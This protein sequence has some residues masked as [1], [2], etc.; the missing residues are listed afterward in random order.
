MDWHLFLASVLFRDNLEE[1]FFWGFCGERATSS[2]DVRGLWVDADVR[3]E[4]ADANNV[5]V[6]TSRVDVP[7][8]PF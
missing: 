7:E 5:D 8:K 6:E 4:A 1:S 2:S 3:V